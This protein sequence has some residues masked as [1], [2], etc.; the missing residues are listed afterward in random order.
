M[1]TRRLSLVEAL[2]NVAIGLLISFFVQI[3]AFHIVGLEASNRQQLGLLAIFT[4][5]SIGRTY[6][7]RRLF[8]RLPWR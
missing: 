5:A 8:E 4:V 3:L 1:Q 2:A 6:V 7:L